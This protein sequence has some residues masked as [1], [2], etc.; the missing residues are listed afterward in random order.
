MKFGLKVREPFHLDGELLQPGYD[1]TDA[2][3]AL[4]V[5]DEEKPEDTERLRRCTRYVIEDNAQDA[6]PAADA[7]PVETEKPK[8]ARTAAKGE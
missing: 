1:L 6:A 8:T 7:A 5:G 3:I 2:Q 4:L